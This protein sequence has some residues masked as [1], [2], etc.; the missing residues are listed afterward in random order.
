MSAA[1]F[2]VSDV[3]HVPGTERT[4][5]PAAYR[6]EDFPGCESFHLPAGEVEH[7]EGRLEFWDGRTETAWKV[8]EPTSIEHEGPSRRLVQM[9]TRFEIL[10]GSRIACFGSA[11]LLRVDATGRKHWLMQADEV[12]YLHPDRVRLAGPAIDVDADPLPDVVLEVDHTTD[13]RRRK[14]GIYKGSGFPEIWVLVPWEAS[15][16]R[17]GLTIHVRRG[18]EYR[19]EPE[20]RAFPGWRAEEIHRALTEAPLSEGAWR[21][22][23][24]VALSMGAREGTK[25]E[26]DPLMRSH[27]AKVRAKGHREGQAQGHREGHERGMREGMMQ[28]RE[29]GIEQ[30]LER[31]LAHER[32]LLR[33]MAASRFGTDTAERLGAVLAAIADP[34]RMAEVGE[35]LV[36]CETGDAFLSRVAAAGTETDRGDD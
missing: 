2:D 26:D 5:E 33:R 14:L 1:S 13:V 3:F 12:L 4:R 10:R 11:D 18:G 36:R 32:A 9:A 8:C 25:P 24:R 22:L 27:S 15:A 29:Q 20:S 7:Y 16:R 6:D 34:E 35:W 21:A 17:P 28:G 31:G 30:G 23:E 19:E